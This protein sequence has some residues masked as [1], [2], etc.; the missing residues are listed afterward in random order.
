MQKRFL[1]Y[2]SIIIFS[3]IFYSCKNVATLYNKPKVKISKPEENGVYPGRVPIEIIVESA[4][5]LSYVKLYD[6]TRFLTE[7]KSYDIRDT[8]R[9]PQ[10]F[11]KLIVEVTDVSGNSAEKSV[12]FFVRNFPPSSPRISILS[13]DQRKK[14][15][16]I[17]VSTIDPDS[18]QI[19]IQV[20]WGDGDSSEWTNYLGSGESIE[21]THTWANAGTYLVR[22][23]AKDPFD[24]TSTLSDPVTIV[25]GENV[26]PNTPSKPIGQTSVFRY[27]LYYYS[28]TAEDPNGDS[29]QVQFSFGDGTMS[30]WSQFVPS[31]YE[32]RIGKI[33]N[34]VGN[35]Y[36]K[37]RCRDKS[38]ATSNWSDS[39]LVTVGNR[40]PSIVGRPSGRDTGFVHKSYVFSVVSTDPERDPIQIQFDFG[41]GITEW[42]SFGASGNTFSFT[43]TWRIGGIYQV[44]ARARDLYGSVSDWSEPLY[45]NIMNFWQKT[46]G[47][48][49]VDEAYSICPAPGGGYVVAGFTGSYWDGYS[50]VYL[51]KIDEGGNKVWE[52]TYGG[53]S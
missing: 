46:Y 22:A 34:S 24:S 5:D 51:L 38:G 41:D 4:E 20:H 2:F 3:L 27:D 49:S 1:A 31:G 32:V 12:N 15:A 23:R 8:L 35:F 50:D 43:K 28:V 25:L 17:K 16:R 36:V 44:K 37:A 19:R 45:V 6:N 52:R 40:P 26:P 9:F 14:F 29:I 48:G 47:R 33:W 11:H 10:G 18:D 7:Y 30:D 39:L 13:V 21:L 53:T 42:S